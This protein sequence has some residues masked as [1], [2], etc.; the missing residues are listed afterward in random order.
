MKRDSVILILLFHIFI[1]RPGLYKHLLLKVGLCLVL[2][3][4]LGVLGSCAMNVFFSL[5]FGHFCH[6]TGAFL[7]LSGVHLPLK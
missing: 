6:C 2:Q 4:L 3:L 5:C 7:L 1:L